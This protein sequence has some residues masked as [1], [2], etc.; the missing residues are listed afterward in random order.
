MN[1]LLVG[2]EDDSTD[3]EVEVEVVPEPEYPEGRDECDDDCDCDQIDN[4]KYEGP[5]IMKYIDWGNLVITK[6]GMEVLRFMAV[7]MKGKSMS[8]NKAEDFLRY[9]A[10]TAPPCPLSPLFYPYPVL[11]LSTCCTNVHTVSPCFATG[12]RGMIPTPMTICL[13]A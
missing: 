12:T 9:H 11:S 2:M 7:V 5:E 13:G 8:Q 6:T 3:D 4:V 10:L 1:A